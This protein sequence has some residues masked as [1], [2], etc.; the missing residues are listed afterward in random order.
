[1]DTSHLTLNSVFLL[2]LVSRVSLVSALLQ[3]AQTLNSPIHFSTHIRHFA[4]AVLV[5]R[6]ATGAMGL[7]QEILTNAGVCL[8]KKP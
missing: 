3:E 5:S 6:G 1:M 7:G 2:T 4:V 8:V